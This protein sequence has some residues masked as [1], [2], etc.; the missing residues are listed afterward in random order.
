MFGW[1][2]SECH[3]TLNTDKSVPLALG[4]GQRTHN[5][6]CSTPQTR[7]QRLGVMDLIASHFVQRKTSENHCVQTFAGAKAQIVE[8]LNLQTNNKQDKMTWK[9]Y[10][11]V[12]NCV[13]NFSEDLISAV[14]LKGFDNTSCPTCSDLFGSTQG[15]DIASRRA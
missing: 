9:Q 11:L 14:K 8:M 3:S 2:L 15:S 5:Q 6:I 4:K 13:H 10:M 1:T 7:P 12:F